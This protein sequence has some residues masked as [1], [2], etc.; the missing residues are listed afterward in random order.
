M[1]PLSI[2][3][4][5]C[6]WNVAFVKMSHGMQKCHK[7]HFLEY[8]EGWL[9]LVFGGNFCKQDLDVC[10]FV[11]IACASDNEGRSLLYQCYF[12][13]CY[14]KHF[15]K[16]SKHYIHDIKRLLLYPM[17]LYHWCPYK[18]SSKMIFFFQS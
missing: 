12:F 10:T 6:I 4:R 8:K 14:F 2:L 13:H 17:N 16:Q 5:V 1:N 9:E 11:L 15:K 7:C 18:V 3:V